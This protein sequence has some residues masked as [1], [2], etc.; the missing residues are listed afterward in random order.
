M[1][2]PLDARSA[3]SL[4]WAAAAAQHLD[5]ALPDHPDPDQPGMPLPAL[6][7]VLPLLRPISSRLVLPLARAH[8]QSNP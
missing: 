6:A 4:A 2:T 8:N 5:D 1:P 7:G 3:A